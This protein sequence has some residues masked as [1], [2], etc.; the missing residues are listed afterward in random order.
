MANYEKRPFHVTLRFKEFE[1]E[2]NAR[3]EGEAKKI[4]FDKTIKRGYRAL[5]D[6]ESTYGYQRIV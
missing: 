4:A 2:V 6:F 1:V 3:T 5:I